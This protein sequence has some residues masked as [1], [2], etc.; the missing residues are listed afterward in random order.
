MKKLID[1]LSTVLTAGA[2]AVC[3]LAVAGTGHAAGGPV[4]H[5]TFDASV[6]L[7]GVVL[8]AGSYT[9]E[10]LRADIVRVTSRDGKRVFYT[11]FTHR[12]PRPRSMAPGVTVL[13][14]EAARGEPVP[15]TA[16]YP[17]QTAS[18]GHRFLHR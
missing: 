8:P 15:L 1:R 16:W 3:L 14:G 7:P 9:F 2:V 5:L 4:N 6:A 18:L 12:V 10:A 13:L 17:E 11:G